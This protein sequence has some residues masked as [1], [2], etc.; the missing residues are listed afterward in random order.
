M[1]RFAAVRSTLALVLVAS[2]GC[3]S[4]GDGER[5]GRPMPGDP[6]DASGGPPDSPDDPAH[7]PGDPPDDSPDGPTGPCDGALVDRTMKPGNIEQASANG[8]TVSLVLTDVDVAL[9]QVLVTIQ[10]DD[11]PTYPSVL[12][13]DEGEPTDNG[14][15]ITALMVETQTRTA[16]MCVTVPSS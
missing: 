12:V 4:V 9:P 5:D 16:R 2:A 1:V 14:F 7:V 13:Q 15:V 10:E 3:A 11:A 6:P 8:H